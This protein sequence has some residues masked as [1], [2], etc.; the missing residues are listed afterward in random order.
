MVVILQ[1]LHTNQT[2]LDIGTVIVLVPLLTLA[3]V[4]LHSLLEVVNNNLISVGFVVVVGL[5]L[6][7][8]VVREL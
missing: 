1:C 6:M 5:F 4:V 7:H 8:L 2:G 3:K